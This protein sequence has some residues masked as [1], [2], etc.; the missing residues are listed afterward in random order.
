[1]AVA[2]NIDPVFSKRAY[3]LEF[4]SD[5]GILHDKFVFSL[6]PESESFIYPQRVNYTKTFSG[7]VADDY[8]NDCVKITLSGSTGSPEVKRVLDGGVEKYLSGEEEIFL[9]QKKLNLWGQTENLKG[10]RI[11]LYDLSKTEGSGDT[12]SSGWWDVSIDSFEITRSKD[13]PLSYHYKLDMTGFPG[14]KTRKETGRSGF[15][16]VVDLIDSGSEAVIK[17]GNMAEEAL[18]SVYE[19]VSDYAASLRAAVQQ[20]QNTK[21]RILNMMNRTVG[22]ASSAV[23]DTLEIAGT[24]VFTGMRIVEETAV[25]LSAD[26][27]AVSEKMEAVAKKC[28]DVMN[29]GDYKNQW[30][31]SLETCGFDNES[32]LFDAVLLA[33]L[34]GEAEAFRLFAAGKMDRET[35]ETV[36]VPGAAE[37]DDRVV[38]I[39]GAKEYTVKSSDTWDSI[40]LSRMGDISQTSLLQRYNAAHGVEELSPG[41]T[42]RIPELERTP[43]NTGNMVT[44]TGSAPY[45]KDIALSGQGDFLPARGDLAVVSGLENLNQAVVS[46]LSTM[47]GTRIRDTLY[48]IRVG[49]GDSG[50]VGAY[51]RASIEET[52]L[53]DP[54]I[55]RIDGL[56]WKGIGDT[57]H[58]T[59]DYTDINGMKHS[60][61]GA[62]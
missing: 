59:V 15:P 44:N 51:L 13:R 8:G 52:L 3:L 31:Q 29:S 62:V 35:A 32:S 26:L 40:A 2:S 55:A 39:F 9:L 53:E 4:F 34:E 10:K 47:A 6:P 11:R 45:G 46:R 57:L 60:A 19:P 17:Y 7:A 43:G 14:G 16:R 41:V 20:V 61:A 38:F 33:N 22:A 1:M 48:G 23:A 58:Y 12:P 5:A 25:N 28:R 49:T 56:S 24:A 50:S 21:T 42:V 36:S 54:R 18:R 27:Q 37:E 30:E